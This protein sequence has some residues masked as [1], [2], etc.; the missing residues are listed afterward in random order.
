MKAFS[1]LRCRLVRR[2]LL[3]GGRDGVHGRTCAGCREF[4]EEQA[5]WETRL[6]RSAGLRREPKP[7]GLDERILAALTDAAPARRFSGSAVVAFAGG[8][9]VLGAALL[10]FLRLPA[11]APGGPVAPAF[12]VSPA[13]A[14][15]AAAPDLL[16]RLPRPAARLLAE[17]PLQD[18]AAFI[19]EDAQSALHFLALNFLPA[20]GDPP[21]RPRGPAPAGE[22]G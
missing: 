9:A 4:F 13:P 2:G 20:A 18:E 21:A 11:G 14:P 6:R 15:A 17:N 5:A 16:A 3:P 22:R 12:A 19:Y 10:L 7:A 8:A 1:S